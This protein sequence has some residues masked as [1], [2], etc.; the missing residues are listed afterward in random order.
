MDN[1]IVMV[2]L[3]KFVLW[4]C[5]NGLSLV[6]GVPMCVRCGS[7]NQCRQCVVEYVLYIDP[8]EEDNPECLSEEEH[9]SE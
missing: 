6:C 9:R 1:G 2:R 8:E 3:R 7:G 5:F 4:W